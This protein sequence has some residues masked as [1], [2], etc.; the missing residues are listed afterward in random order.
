MKV[1]AIPLFRGHFTAVVFPYKPKNKSEKVCYYMICYYLKSI[2][3]LKDLCS[4]YLLFNEQDI[5]DPSGHYMYLQFKPS[6]VYCVI[7]SYSMEQGILLYY[8][9][10]P[11]YLKL[12]KNYV[13]LA[14]VSNT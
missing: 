12:F 11:E 13:G 3:V 10:M 6:H 4:V 5:P 14:Q 8:P 9:E 2:F 1:I 7:P